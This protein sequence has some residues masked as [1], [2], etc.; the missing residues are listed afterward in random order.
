MK[1][2]K[3]VVL[4]TTAC[5]SDCL[6]PASRRSVMKRFRKSRAHSTVKQVINSLIWM[7]NV[8]T[9]LTLIAS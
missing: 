7:S 6:I 3:T 1:K 4:L 9:L 2:R 5:S 8:R